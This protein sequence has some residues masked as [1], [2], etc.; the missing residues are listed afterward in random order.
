MLI[1]TNKV[2]LLLMHA[3]LKRNIKASVNMGMYVVGTKT[4]KKLS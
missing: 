2:I 3:N 1:K 4:N